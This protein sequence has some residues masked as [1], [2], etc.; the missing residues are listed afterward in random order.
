MPRNRIIPLTQGQV[1]I[2]DAT[3]LEWLSESSWCAARK[4]LVQ[5]FYAVRRPDPRRMHHAIWIHHNGPIPDGLTV[6][7][8]DRDTLNNCL[9]N[10]RLATFSQQ[11]QNRRVPKNNISGYRGVSWR[12]ESGKWRA[13]LGR[14]DGKIIS[15]GTFSD[16]VEA[17][18]A[19]DAAA[20]IHHDPEFVQL[21]F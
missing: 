21:N 5:T 17:A 3:D 20:K 10:L 12:K 14:V 7:H 6:D 11:S 13:T 18:R 2:V 15:L 1:A 9:S 16:P 19:Y 4:Q 8:A